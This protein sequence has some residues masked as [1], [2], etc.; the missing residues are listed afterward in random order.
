MLL[1]LTMIMG[2]TFILALEKFTNT[3]V[4][5]AKLETY[6]K[7][8]TYIFTVEMVFKNYALGIKGYLRDGYNIFDG[9]LVMVSLF[10]VI[11]EL[12]MGKS[13]GAGVLSVFR[14]LRLLRVFKLA[15]KSKGLLILL[16]V[17]YFLIIINFLGNHEYFKRYRLLLFATC[18]IHIHMLIIGNG[19]VCFQMQIRKC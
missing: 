15:T 11:M 3:P 13:T 18:A 2:N 17:L 12:I 5:N 9:I 19:S 14:T 1:S 7:M 6:N 8:F 4:T 16:T 10:D